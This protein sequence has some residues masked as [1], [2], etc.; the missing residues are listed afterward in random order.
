MDFRQVIFWEWVTENDWTRKKI[1]VRATRNSRDPYKGRR[2][3]QWDALSDYVVDDYV[4]LVDGTFWLALIDNNG[5]SPSEGAT[6]TKFNR[7]DWAESDATKVLIIPGLKTRVIGKPGAISAHPTKELGKLTPESREIVMRDC[8]E[9]TSAD[10]AVDGTGTPVNINFLSTDYKSFLNQLFDNVDGL[11]TW[12]YNQIIGSPAYTDYADETMFNLY[13]MGDSKNELNTTPEEIDLAPGTVNTIQMNQQV[14]VTIDSL[15]SRMASFTI[16]DFLDTTTESDGDRRAFFAGYVATAGETFVNGYKNDFPPS[17]GRIEI[18]N[19]ATLAAQTINDNL[20]YI[21]YESILY[22]MAHLLGATTDATQW[23]TKAE[24]WTDVTNQTTGVI[25]SNRLPIASGY[26]IISSTGVCFEEKFGCDP[27]CNWTAAEMSSGV[28]LTWDTNISDAISKWAT[29]FFCKIVFDYDQTSKQ[30][31][32][33]LRDILENNVVLADATTAPV[34]IGDT[35]I[36]VSD[37]AAMFAASKI[38]ELTDGKSSEYAVA[39]AGSGTTLTLTRPQA[40]A[41]T[42]TGVTVNAIEELPESWRLKSSKKE[43]TTISQGHVEV[44]AE[45]DED[46][47]ASPNLKGEAI[48]KQMSERTKLFSQLGTKVQFTRDNATYNASIT[49]E[50]QYSTW[51][52]FSGG[53]MARWIVPDDA[54]ITHVGTVGHIKVYYLESLSSSFSYLTRFPSDGVDYH[55]GTWDIVW[56]DNGAF[57]FV[58][59]DN[60]WAGFGNNSNGQTKITFAISDFDSVDPP[61]GSNKSIRIGINRWITNFAITEGV[62]TATTVGGDFTGNDLFGNPL[63]GQQVIFPDYGI[64]TITHA[65]YVAGTGTATFDRPFPVDA[66]GVTGYFGGP[67]INPDGWLVGAFMYYDNGSDQRFHSLLYSNSLTTINYSIWRPYTPFL[68]PAAGYYYGAYTCSRII[69][70]INELS[71]NPAIPL[72]PTDNFGCES[73]TAAQ[74][75]A[76]YSIGN[77]SNV[78]RQYDGVTD[79]SGYIS[80]V[81]NGAM[82][83]EYR[84][85]AIRFYQVVGRGIDEFALGRGVTTVYGLEKR[86]RRPLSRFKVWVKGRNAS[87]GGAASV[88]ASGGVSG[89]GNSNASSG[90]TETIV[91][92]HFQP[93]RVV[94]LTGTGAVTMLSTAVDA[95][96]VISA[97]ITS[98]LQPTTIIAPNTITIQN[99]SGADIVT[100]DFK[101]PNNSTWLCM[102]MGGATQYDPNI[103]AGWNFWRFDSNI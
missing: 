23:T 17:S 92:S 62:T 5:I 90:G 7:F 13:W 25:E 86:P 74:V 51:R 14:H 26:T 101:V 103:A 71:T 19:P 54:T 39:T 12:S 56:F 77:F 83:Y 80:G 94:T 73:Y 63:I 6:W 75:Y 21:T 44:K 37:A 93:D 53:N 76:S 36:E 1:Q 82:F 50:N 69:Y 64:F 10:G 85:G 38:Q 8:F 15:A 34:L 45:S 47:L 89:G 61:T 60:N 99:L 29:Q 67:D 102:F 98:V 58:V 32:F 31:V 42:N 18:P 72:P 27:R 52:L 40:I 78:L 68:P 33:L 95:L 20:H 35:T 87:S 100:G 70:G 2:R 66:T 16:R 81:H 59:E 91:T 28:S 46:V 4:A 24:V 97:G 11:T 9:L 79:A 43:Q 3:G 22:K 88:G 55:D 57:G 30:P 96:V 65:I 41:W 84:E 48:Q 49:P